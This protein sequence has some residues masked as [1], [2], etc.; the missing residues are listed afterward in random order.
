M[1][2]ENVRTR[3]P[4]EEDTEETP[5]PEKTDEQ[6]VGQPNVTG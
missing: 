6:G 5:D 2:L 3:K 1:K 4:G